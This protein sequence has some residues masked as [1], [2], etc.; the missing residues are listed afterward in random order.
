[1]AH[2]N[3]FLIF[4]DLYQLLTFSASINH[5]TLGPPHETPGVTK[6]ETVAPMIH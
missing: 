6:N 2:P 1:M 4:R 5:F 3:S